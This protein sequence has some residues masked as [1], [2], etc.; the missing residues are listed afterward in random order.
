[1]SLT[2]I[3]FFFFFSKIETTL[4]SHA[5]TVHQQHSPKNNHTLFF[6]LRFF[7]LFVP[8]A[9]TAVHSLNSRSTNRARVD[10]IFPFV[11]TSSTLHIAQQQQQQRRNAIRAKPSCLACVCSIHSTAIT[12]IHSLYGVYSTHDTIYSTHHGVAQTLAYRPTKTAH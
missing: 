4:L 5:K 2:Y 12:N 6:R 11:Q 7:G 3:Y 10:Y 9:F 8:L 1:M